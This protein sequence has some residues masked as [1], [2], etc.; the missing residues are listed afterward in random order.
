M[1]LAVRCKE[2]LL[3]VRA[4]DDDNDR[5]TYEGNLSRVTESMG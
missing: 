5:A 2:L 3:L 4:D 1:Y